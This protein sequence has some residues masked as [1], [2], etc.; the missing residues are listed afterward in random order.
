MKK[1]K[2]D[3]GVSV[4][5]LAIFILTFILITFLI[6]VD[7]IRILYAKNY[8]YEAARRAA[9]TSIKQQNYIGG[10]TIES[11][12][13][14]RK[15][16]LVQRNTKGFT[17]IQR[18]DENFLS[19]IIIKQTSDGAFIR[20]GCENKMSNLPKMSIK[21]DTRRNL[22]V[23]PTD[24]SP[25]YIYTI[26]SADLPENMFPDFYKKKYKVINAEVTDYISAGFFGCMPIKVNV[27]AISTSVYDLE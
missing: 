16:Y 3:T 6:G 5:I 15:E 9:E 13:R 11:A 23:S 25:A 1:L 8:Y 12:N 7:L 4:S 2:E 21:F 10:L 17:N 20:A 19:N 14:F 18:E 24:S 26:H 27:S 22:G